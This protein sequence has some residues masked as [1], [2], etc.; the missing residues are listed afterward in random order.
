MLLSGVEVEL[1]EHLFNNFRRIDA[2]HW[3]YPNAFLLHFE[4]PE[5]SQAV[6]VHQKEEEKFEELE[7]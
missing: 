4:P 2:I 6:D 5:T 3:S 7:N 1:W